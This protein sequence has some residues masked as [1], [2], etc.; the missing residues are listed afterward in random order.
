MR[1]TLGDKKKEPSYQSFRI[2]NS[3]LKFSMLILEATELFSLCYFS[4]SST[5]SGLFR[6]RQRGEP[7][8]SC[9]GHRH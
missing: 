6:E 9:H 3:K 2:E 5:S 8:E 4:C 7:E 1:V